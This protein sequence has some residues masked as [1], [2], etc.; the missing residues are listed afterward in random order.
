M[1]RAPK[2]SPA[3]LALVALLAVVV[4]AVLPALAQQAKLT[5]DDDCTVFAFSPS[6]DRIVYA[7]R[8]IS[9]ESVAKGKKMLVEHDDIW[10]VTIDGH[11]KRL[12]EG[13]KLVKSPVPV[14]FQIQAIRIAPDDRHMTVQMITRALV[15]NPEGASSGKVQSGE[16]TD[17]MDGEGKEIN[18][19]GTNPKNSAIFGATNAVW[20]ADGQTVV[21][22][23]QPKDSLL[24]KIAYV[25]PEGGTGGA[26]LPDRYFAAVAWSPAHNAGA[27][28]ER[29][30]N[31]G[32]PI[33]LVWIDLIHKTERTLATL[34][35]YNGHLTVSHSGK[36][37]AYFRDGNTIEIRSVADPEKITSFKVAF[38][39]YEWSADDT[40]LLL[41][42]GPN[43][44]TDQL[45]WISL[46]SG[47]F[48][49][50][51]HGLI[52]HDFHVSPDGRWVAVT[53][54]GKQILKLFPTP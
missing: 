54:P 38:G 28:I 11:K 52:Y 8:Q 6:G 31:L 32:G 25:R 48:D 13:K 45:L 51:F 49:Y 36:Q 21:Y 5:V 53:E 1:S 43:D 12:L 23:T 14:S 7:S 41:K 50:A 30:K 35:G 39:R 37:I 17:L 29:D 40:H 16:L 33:R 9:N 47:T 26:I 3:P 20:L 42:R 18:V 4:A 10:R 19:E 27:A 2:R 44:Q 34:A 15:P 24:Y 22:L 46:P